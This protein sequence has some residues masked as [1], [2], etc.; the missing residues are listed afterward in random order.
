MAGSDTRQLILQ[1]DASVA[2]AQRNLKSL[3][4]SVEAETRGIEGSLRRIDG[5][6]QKLGHTL[7]STRT[8]MLEL[9]HVGRATA[10]QFA[11]GTPLTQIFTQHLAQLGQAAGNAGGAMGK[12]GVFLGGPWGIALTLATVVLAKLAF[13]TEKEKDSV[14]ALLEKMREHADKAQ[15]NREADDLWRKSVEGLTAAV[16]DR[17][18]AMQKSRTE[19]DAQAER[20]NVLARSAIAAALAQR[21][22]IQAILERARAEAQSAGGTTFGAAGGAGAG[23]ATSVYSER[24]S[25]LDRLLADNTQQIVDAQ[26]LL[27]KSRIELAD[28]A[29]KLATD[30]AARIKKTYNDLTKAAKDAAGSINNLSLAQ[31]NSLANQIADIDRNRN[32]AIEAL[33]ASK[34]HTREPNQQYGREIDIS[35]A[36]EIVQGLGGRVTSGNRTFAEQ[37]RLYDTVRTPEN[38]VA[39]P[40][41]SAHEKGNALDV[42][43]GKG[44]T[45][46]SLRKAFAEEGVRLTKVLKETG[47]FHIEF[48]TAGADKTAHKA[49]AAAAKQLRN[50]GSFDQ[51]NDREDKELL[52]AQREIIKDTAI[53][54]RLAEQEVLA[55]Q[56]R[57][58]DSINQNLKQGDITKAQAKILLGK[59]QQIAD[60]R[61][62]NIRAVEADRL[63][64]EINQRTTV[65]AATEI[66]HLKSQELLAVTLRQRRDIQIK[67]VDAM[68]QIEINAQQEIID[69]KTASDA[70]KEI[71]RLMLIRARQQN[72]DAHTNIQRQNES[73]GQNYMRGLKEA[74]QRIGEDFQSIGAKGLSSLNSGLV[75]AITGTRKLGSVF[76]DVAKQ[77]INDLLQIAIRKAVIEPLAK[78]LFGGGSGG[79]GGGI[80]S[81]LGSLGSLFGGGKGGGGSTPGAFNY[82][83]GSGGF[84][85]VLGARASGGPVSGGKP[86]MVGENGPEIIVP[87]ASGVVIPNNKIGGGGSNTTVVMNGVITND[88]FWA[89]IDKRSHVTL[90]IASQAGAQGGQALIAQRQSR[91]I[92]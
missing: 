10:D 78:A 73:P 44:I 11:A 87:H 79:S 36:T 81:L 33:S 31:A 8:S 27:S 22:L 56:K 49:D 4:A 90:A 15:K 69:S 30:P 74:D 46:D 84:L 5:A 64:S 37:Q 72:N 75:D 35:R 63:A 13:S 76:H 67:I 47:H 43:Y 82:G 14:E 26:K 50:Q 40:G 86:Y 25:A 38:P 71:A 32:K 24:A 59:E 21:A 57:V 23:M 19:D 42:A 39:R 88:Q 45:V 60:Q 3:S 55:D 52:V 29:A 20:D 66:D 89:E 77:I 80:G 7:G 17:I 51:S 61:I 1:V 54:A 9:G 16:R 92:P 48:S 58:D 62:A 91:M 53:R 41:T 18:A 65:I 34:R 2:L 68:T 70:Q 85:S 6:H 83:T 12:F 28:E